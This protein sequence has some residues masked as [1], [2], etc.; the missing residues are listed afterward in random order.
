MIVPQAQLVR[1]VMHARVDDDI[2][3]WAKRRVVESQRVLDAQRLQAMREGYRDGLAAALEDVVA[4]L[5]RTEHLCDK[6]RSDMTEQVREVLTSASQHPHALLAALDDAVQTL[7]GPRSATSITIVLPLRLKPRREEILA[8]VSA[9]AQMPVTLEFRARDARISVM[10]GDA[11]I[12]YD[13]Q[14]YVAR[15]EAALDI[16]PRA[17]RQD[18]RD[19][20]AASLSS[21]TERVNELSGC[22]HTQAHEVSAGGRAMGQAEMPGDALAPQDEPFRNGE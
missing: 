3:H 10:R 17:P 12:E 5:M 21:L 8:R 13:P 11:V 20:L 16:D 7:A 22:S 6:W 9:V 15:A 1:G 4:H 14:D 18:L 19:L 2:R